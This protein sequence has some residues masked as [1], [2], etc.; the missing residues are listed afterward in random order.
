MGHLIGL[1]STHPEWVR[2]LLESQGEHLR[3][4]NPPQ[5]G[6][7]GIGFYQQGEVLRRLSPLE[8]SGP[9]DFRDMARGVRTAVLIGHVRR[10]SAGRPTAANTHPFRYRDWLFAHSG[11]IPRLDDLRPS[12][13]QNVPLFLERNVSGET[14]SEILFHMMLA[15]LHRLNVLDAP[16]TPIDAACEAIRRAIREADEALASVHA[17]PP[18]FAL[19]AT[20]GS[21]MVGACRREPMFLAQFDRL[22][23]CRDCEAG[24]QRSRPC[25]ICR[26]DR[27]DLRAALLASYPP[28]M[29][30]RYERLPDEALIGIKPDATVETLPFRPSA[31]GLR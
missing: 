31:I 17:A 4:P 20:N 25:E 3:V 28:P 5:P 22:V 29:P 26:S 14:D 10:A 8:R 18:P 21:I 7:W 19:L 11:E 1:L 6:G 2:C 12:L 15:H 16:E 13:L 9:L 27:R 23:D 30:P 24:E